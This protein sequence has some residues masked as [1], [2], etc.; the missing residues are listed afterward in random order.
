MKTIKE[1]PFIFLKNK[2]YNTKKQEV[3]YKLIKII[4]KNT[5]FGI[6]IRLED[7]DTDVGQIILNLEYI[8]Q[9]LLDFFLILQIKK[10]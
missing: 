3:I 4:K 5:L 6:A 10:I 2:N 8:K 9:E 7:Q 1:V